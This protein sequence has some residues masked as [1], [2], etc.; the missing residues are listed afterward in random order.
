MNLVGCKQVGQQRKNSSAGDGKAT[1]SW[2]WGE[3]PSPPV[4]RTSPLKPVSRSVS[5][6]TSPVAGGDGN[7]NAENSNPG[8]DEA[9]AEQ[10][11]ELAHQTT[12]EE[13]SG[14]IYLDDFNE[15]DP[16]LAALYLP[17]SSFR[18]GFSQSVPTNFHPRYR[19]GV[20]ITM[21]HQITLFPF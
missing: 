14:G 16:E 8:V 17:Q 7:L 10:R 13:E 2:R 11:K 9:V 1:Q 19:A 18:Q 15:L 20:C 5:R 4:V 3:L 6:D 21:I 12:T